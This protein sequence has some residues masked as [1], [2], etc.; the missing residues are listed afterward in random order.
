M[1]LRNWIISKRASS[2]VPCRVVGISELLDLLP[3]D[4]S[5]KEWLSQIRWPNGVR[6]CGYD[7]VSVSSHRQMKCRCR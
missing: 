4:N 3:D 6:C 7:R 2:T 5:A 1:D